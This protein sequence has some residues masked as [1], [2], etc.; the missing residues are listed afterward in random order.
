MTSTVL[1]CSHFRVHGWL[2]HVAGQQDLNP[3]G[4]GQR[5]FLFF[6]FICFFCFFKILLLP[7]QKKQKKQKNIFH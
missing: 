2:E 3:W 7:K 4:G 1:V 6:C 5:I